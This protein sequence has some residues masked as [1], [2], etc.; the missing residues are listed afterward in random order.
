MGLDSTLKIQRTPRPTNQAL[1]LHIPLF[2]SSYEWVSRFYF[3]YSNVPILFSKWLQ[4]EAPKRCVPAFPSI[5]GSRN[6]QDWPDLCPFTT[7]SEVVTLLKENKTQTVR[8]CELLPSTGDQ[9]W[10]KTRNA[11][12]S[13]RYA[14]NHYF[15]ERRKGMVCCFVTQIILRERGIKQD[16]KQRKTFV[17]NGHEALSEKLLYPL[18]TAFQESICQTTP[19]NSIFLNCSMRRPPEY[20]FRKHKKNIYNLDLVK[21]LS[22]HELKVTAQHTGHGTFEVWTSQFQFIQK[23][24]CSFFTGIYYHFHVQHPMAYVSG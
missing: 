20:A 11:E 13:L 24:S 10:E 7:V 6:Q 4:R 23:A 15:R 3:V 16:T 19:P 12:S 14:K 17:T 9:K 22:I 8:R 2:W 1:L 18:S 21:T 5:H